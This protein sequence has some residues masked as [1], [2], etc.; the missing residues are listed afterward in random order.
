[1]TNKTHIAVINSAKENLSY[2]LSDFCNYEDVEN[3]V[4]IWAFDVWK[5]YIHE[6]IDSLTVLIKDMEARKYK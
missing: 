3:T 5:N 1:M 6:T 2:L 4:H